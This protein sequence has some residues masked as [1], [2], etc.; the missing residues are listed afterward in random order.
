MKYSIVHVGPEK[1]FNYK[2]DACFGILGSLIELGYDVD[3]RNNDFAK[4]RTNIVIGID[5][6]VNNKS[7]NLLK[8]NDIEYIAM[9]GEMVNHGTLNN[10]KNFNFSLYSDYLSNAK[11]IIT[12]FK[13]NVLELAKIGF[14]SQY[15]RWGDYP[16]RI[17]SAAIS[18]KP[19]PL[20]YYGMLKGKRLDALK[21]IIQG[22]KE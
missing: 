17:R 12:P 2:A 11:A 7:T 16:G 18:Q 4:D 14:N 1:W 6:L 15:F 21:N 22:Y 10:R 5:W 9:E 13:H 20:A 8:E 3:F 19:Y